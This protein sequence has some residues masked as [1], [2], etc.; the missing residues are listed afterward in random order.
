MTSKAHPQRYPYLIT[1]TD[2]LVAEMH[3]CN[4]DR[5]ARPT[6][7]T[8]KGLCDAGLLTLCYRGRVRYSRFSKRRGVNLGGLVWK[9]QTC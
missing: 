8:P 6:A 1:D 2:S 7:R 3:Q 5:L 4:S 9:Q